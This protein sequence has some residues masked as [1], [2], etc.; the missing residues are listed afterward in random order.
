M[1]Y[2]YIRLEFTICVL[3]LLLLFV[4]YCVELWM[5]K[6]IYNL[7]S[8]SSQVYHPVVL[9]N[10]LITNSSFK[11]DSEIHDRPLFSE[12][13]KPKQLNP[14]TLEAS[15]SDVGA[16]DTWLLI[17]VFT[18]DHKIYALFKNKNENKKYLKLSENQTIAGWL[19]KEIKPSHVLLE[20]SGQERVLE[21][22]TIKP[23]VKPSADY[24]PTL[25]R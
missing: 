1:I 6:S 24:D 7:N 13:R 25:K 3:L 5:D 9:P 20:L 16:L 14:I 23:K 18:K 19:I 10:L 15:A 12:D 2:N 17:G 21:L 22:I 4:E 11:D 8:S